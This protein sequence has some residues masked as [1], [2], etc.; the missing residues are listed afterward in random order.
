MKCTEC[1]SGF[2][3][4]DGV[5]CIT[6]EKCIT[7]ANHVPVVARVDE[8]ADNEIKLISGAACI[9]PASKVSTATNCIYAPSP[10]ANFLG[11]AGE[12]SYGCIECFKGYAPYLD[13]ANAAKRFA[14]IPG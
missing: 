1:E 9:V 2:Y 7:N 14:Y 6:K 5:E 3:L 10:K 11:G 4:K 13:T 8:S 12:F